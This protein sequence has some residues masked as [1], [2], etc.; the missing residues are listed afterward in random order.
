MFA[1]CE[2]TVFIRRFQAARLRHAEPAAPPR[3]MCLIMESTYGI[4]GTDCRHAKNRSLSSLPPWHEFLEAGRTPV[5]HAYVLGKA[6][7]I[8]RILTLAGLR[9]VQHPLVHASASL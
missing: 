1:G 4:H 8:T 3:L 7:E 6:Q 9:V 2:G 5:V